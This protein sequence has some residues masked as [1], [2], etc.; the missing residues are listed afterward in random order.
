MF[1]YLSILFSN[2]T[3]CVCFYSP[4]S[5]DTKTEVEEESS[6]TLKNI[7]KN[8]ETTDRLENN[9]P[10]STCKNRHIVVLNS[11]KT[12]NY[13][14]GDVIRRDT[15]SYPYHQQRKEEQK[16]ITYVMVQ[17]DP[18][19]NVCIINLIDIPSLEHF[20]KC[21]KENAKDSSPSSI[22]AAFMIEIDKT[23]YKFATSI[24]LIVLVC[25]PNDFNLMKYM[26][27]WVSNRGHIMALVFIV[28]P[29]MTDKQREDH[30]VSIREH[31]KFRENDLGDFFDKGLF[32]ISDL[33]YNHFKTAEEQTLAQTYVKDWR[34]KFL[35]VCVGGPNDKNYAIQI[36]DEKQGKSGNCNLS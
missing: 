24:D 5:T 21:A 33:S 28:S 35:R 8:L 20:N 7:W 1:Y 10:F 32:C 3:T 2:I 14:V 27:H 23:I 15:Y 36:Q 29:T 17:D 26:K 12:K 11:R 4:M 19:C 31:E 22:A 18:S 25:E 30:L 16:T 9:F 13:I 34:S 6:T